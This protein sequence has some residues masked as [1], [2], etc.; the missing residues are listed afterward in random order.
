MFIGS[1]TGGSKIIC[2]CTNL[3][4]KA[5]IG[6][7]NWQFCQLFLEVFLDSWRFSLWG[8]GIGYIW[9]EHSFEDHRLPPPPT[10]KTQASRKPWSANHSFHIGNSKTLCYL[11]ISN[12]VMSIEF[13]ISSSLNLEG[14]TLRW[15]QSVLAE[16][17][18]VCMWV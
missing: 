7:S 3:K 17:S 14:L 8:G 13:A 6:R 16:L 2:T 1:N 11:T 12:S 4:S 9:G 10:K 18:Q 15:Y 5:Q